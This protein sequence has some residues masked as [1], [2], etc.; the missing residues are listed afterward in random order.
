MGT[1]E[2]WQRATLTYHLNTLQ[3]LDVTGDVCVTLNR[4]DRPRADC[5]ID[6]IEYAHPVFD[7][8]AVRAQ[9]RVDEISGV[10]GTYYCGA[11]WNYGFH[12]DGVQSALEVA[13][14]FG[15]TL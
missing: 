6:H 11:Y 7:S 9:R 15:A 13:R 4:P 8:A 5:V 10:G 3:G 14:H 2:R 12:E 1:G